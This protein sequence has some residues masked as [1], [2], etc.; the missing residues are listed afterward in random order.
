MDP[1]EEIA[2]NGIH[3]R[4]R[5]R[6]AGAHKGGDTMANCAEMKPGDRFVCENCGLEL[7]VT[8]ACSCGAG[9]EGAC[10]VPL[11]CCGKDMTKQ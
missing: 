1:D 4:R 8:K 7:Q 6:R 9:E 11:K 3:H 5:A 2:D 10:T